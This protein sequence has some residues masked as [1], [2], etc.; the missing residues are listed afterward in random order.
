ME[1][2]KTNIVMIG[3]I[4]IVPIIFFSIIIGSTQWSDTEKNEIMQKDISLMD[5]WDNAFY[6]A[7]PGKK[8][9][10]DLISGGE[11]GDIKTPEDN[12]NVWDIRENK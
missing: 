5:V 7:V 10:F 11:D 9:D 4:L 6:Y 12:I 3:I 2:N 1:K 8:E